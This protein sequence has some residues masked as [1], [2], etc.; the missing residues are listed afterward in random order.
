MQS[1][2]YGEQI[3][4]VGQNDPRFPKQYIERQTASHDLALEI[5]QAHMLGTEALQD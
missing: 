5:L 2:L 1:L 3:Y 4:A